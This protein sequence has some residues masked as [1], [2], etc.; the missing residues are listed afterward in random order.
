VDANVKCFC[1]DNIDGVSGVTSAYI[2]LQKFILVS[3]HG[4]TLVCRN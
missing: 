2:T 4:C 1:P 3:V